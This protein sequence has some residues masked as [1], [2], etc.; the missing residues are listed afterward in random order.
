MS[1]VNDVG[2]SENVHLRYYKDVQCLNLGKILF[3]IY[4]N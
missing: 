2:Y 3:G 1:F 4:L